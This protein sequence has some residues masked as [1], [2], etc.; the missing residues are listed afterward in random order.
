[1][2]APPGCGSGSA[3]HHAPGR[4]AE[5]APSRREVVRGRAVML[6]V[7]QSGTTG[8]T[9]GVQMDR[10]L[11]LTSEDETRGHP[12]R[13]EP[14]RNRTMVGLGELSQMGCDPPAVVERVDKATD[15]VAPGLLG[16]LQDR[17]RAS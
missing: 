5:K 6:A 11:N 4:C 8:K 16:R 13:L 2:A 9:G 7:I 3:P 17:G 14:T 1:M 15:T 12:T 10:K